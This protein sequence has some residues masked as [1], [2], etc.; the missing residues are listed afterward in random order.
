MWNQLE[1]LNVVWNFFFII[2]LFYC[3]DFTLL[4]FL[5]VVYFFY[6][7]SFL[8]RNKILDQFCHNDVIMQVLLINNNQVT[9]LS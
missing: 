5:S 3:F 9:Q 6:L 1:S 4:L 2:V 7:T 8:V